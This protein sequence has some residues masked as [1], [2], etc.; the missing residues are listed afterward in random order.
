MLIKSPT[1][2]LKKN[3]HDCA[4][5]LAMPALLMASKPTRQPTRKPAPTSEND[6]PIADLSAFYD[7]PDPRA[8]YAALHALDYQ[9]PR[10]VQNVARWC[11]ENK[12]IGDFGPDTWILDVGCGFATNAA[13]LRHGI[14][15]FDLYARYDDPILTAMETNSLREADREHFSG[16][17]T[18]GDKVAGLE[19][20]Q[21]ALNY[22]VECGL[23]NAAFREDLTQNPPTDALRDVI[24]QT[25]VIIES[26]VPIFIFPYVLDRILT[27]CAPGHR[28]W[29]VTAPPR[30]TDLSIY[31]AILKKH[32]YVLE[33]AHPAP[34]PHRRFVSDDERRNV[35]ADQSAMGL[36]NTQEETTGYICVT[37][38]L[39]R[40]SN[41]INVTVPTLF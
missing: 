34:L 37:M 17:E 30:Y 33:P 39:A 3:I 29:I 36:D 21:N 38:F 18:T 11:C 16:L 13:G 10:H 1:F 25:T 7:E 8:Y 40:P 23:L 5:M 27:A 31:E 22:G 41:E 24:N 35:I 4:S 2:E 14:D 9:T 32:G 20:A 19:V 15:P 6:V 12:P 26:G 28:P